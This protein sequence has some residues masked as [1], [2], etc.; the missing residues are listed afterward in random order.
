MVLEPTESETEELLQEPLLLDQQQPAH[1]PNPSSTSSGLQRRGG[2]RTITLELEEQPDEDFIGVFELRCLWFLFQFA[3]P[4][5]VLSTH[6]A[7]MD[8]EEFILYI[9]APLVFAFFV[10][11]SAKKNMI[12]EFGWKDFVPT[13]FWGVLIVGGV[14]MLLPVFAA[15]F[16][17]L[18]ILLM[19]LT[20]ILCFK[21]GPVPA[22]EKQSN[23][24]YFHCVVKPSGSRVNLFR[25]LE[26]EFLEQQR[27]KEESE[28]YQGQLRKQ[29]E[30]MQQM[31]E[32]TEHPSKPPFWVPLAL[33]IIAVW[34]VAFLLHAFF[35]VLTREMRNPEK[36]EQKRWHGFD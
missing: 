25:D 15:V 26:E 14:D 19:L 10:V 31:D 20:V 7:M 30:R 18:T 23:W 32:R 4:T 16:G 11:S 33:V 5:L 27:E 34:Q 36:V 2:T 1:D 6:G 12:R 13:V 28:E 22:L 21:L 24:L 29:Q 35:Y 9:V 3:W 8:S 17:L